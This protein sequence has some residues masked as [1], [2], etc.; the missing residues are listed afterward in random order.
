MTTSKVNNT[1]QV[2]GFY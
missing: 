1:I 2:M